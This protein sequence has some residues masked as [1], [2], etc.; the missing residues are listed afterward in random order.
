MH[1][2]SKLLQSWRGKASQSSELR[3]SEDAGGRGE[4]STKWSSSE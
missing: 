4:P 3:R 2:Q 1:L